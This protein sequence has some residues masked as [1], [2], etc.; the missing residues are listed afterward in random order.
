MILAGGL[1]A[2]AMI[3]TCQGLAGWFA[4][5]VFTRRMIATPAGG[6][7]VTVL[8][9]L[10]G[11]EPM[12][13]AALSTLCEQQYPPGFQIVFGV[14][15]AD[16]AAIPVVRALQA[17][18]PGRDMELIIDAAQHGANPKVSSLIN[19]LPSARHDILV[20]ADSDVHAHPDYL[21][22]L[23][24][25]LDRPGVGLVTTLY[26]GLPAFP[27]LASLL[28]ATQITHGFLP[29]ALLGRAFGRRDC[30]GATMCLRRHT[31]DRV[32]G[33]SM[34]RN[35]LADD[36]VLGRRVSAEGLDVALART[37]VAT[38]VPERTFAALWRH[39]LRW[40]RTIRTLEPAAFA[41]SIL[42]YPLFFAGLAMLAAGF[43]AW[44]C[45]FFVLVW[46]VRA[47]AVA[48]IDRALDGPL[49]G[50]AFRG[51]L[52]LL[53]LRDLLSAAEWVASHA[54]RRVEWR[55]QSLQADTPPRY[56][57]GS[58]VP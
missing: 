7:P 38:T 58:H 44:T 50:L 14:H 13:E 37:V 49:A 25:T 15:T 41:A 6:L 26:T 2:L 10:H 29:G 28:G 51:P 48:G 40:A 12:L 43:A 19:M 17:R 24:H 53:P 46:L 20:I 42:Q 23:V 34:L 22:Q 39:E 47:G 1:A 16:D 32:G 18:Y 52:W 36:Q 27:A 21:Q 30:L 35:H 11:A 45:V 57:Q 33:L 4:V 8:K 55:G 3:G 54:G 56:T 5:T 31:L 9:P